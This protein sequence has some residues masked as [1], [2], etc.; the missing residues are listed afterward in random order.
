MKCKILLV[1]FMAILIAQPLFALTGREIMEKSDALPEPRTAMS[2]LLMLVYK[3]ERVEEKEFTLQMKQ[4]PNDEDK[5]LIAFIR[6]TQI[7]LLTHAHKGG[8][9]DQWL[10][11]SSGRIKR[12]AASDKGQPFV[13]S[14]F[15]YQDLSSTDI[16]EH[17]Y[18]LLG[19]E[20]AVGDAC[21]KVQ[22]VKT[23]GD[24]VYDKLDLYVRKTD[25]FVVRIDF[26]KDGKFHKFLE[27]HHVKEIDGILTPYK[28]KMERADGKG[29]TELTLRGVKYNAD[30]ADMTFRREALR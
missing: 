29:K 2:R 19:E 16:D 26:Y 17:E 21:Y 6:P 9:D 24:K 15:Y 7:K 22:G 14:H 30:I 5:T 28:V 1:C 8:D 10:R 20:E 25:Y 23:A 3:G 13:N 4:Y 11:L 12:I 18:E 27:N